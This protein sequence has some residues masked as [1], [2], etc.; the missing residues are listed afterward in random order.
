MTPGSIPRADNLFISFFSSC[1]YVYKWKFSTPRHVRTPPK[2]SKK[3]KVEDGPTPE[4][5]KH[6]LTHK[7]VMDM[8]SDLVSKYG[9][10][11]GTAGQF[12]GRLPASSSE[13]QFET[14][15]GDDDEGAWQ[16]Q[17]ARDIV[18]MPVERSSNAPDH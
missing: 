9:V 1:R 16:S 13:P 10:A 15:G 2:E 18:K 7:Q 3:P 8:A 17:W 5:L 14:K 12:S 11:P 4:E 6:A